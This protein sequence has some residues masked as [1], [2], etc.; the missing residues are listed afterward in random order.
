MPSGLVDHEQDALSLA[1]SYFPGEVLQRQGEHF[2]ADGGQDEPVNLSGFR[3]CESVEVGP[4]VSLVDL[5]EG[6]VPLRSREQ[7]DWQREKIGFR[8]TE[9]NLADLKRVPI[10]L[11]PLDEQHHIVA[12][13]AD[14]RAKVDML[15]RMQAESAAELDALLPSILDRAFKG[16]L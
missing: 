9:L 3:S 6:Q 12:Y 5:H 2:C 16:E 15:K 13:L 8:L 7:G 11:P 4:L 1:R 14:L 10:P